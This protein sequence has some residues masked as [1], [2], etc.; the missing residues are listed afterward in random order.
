MK[1]LF[2][3]TETKSRLGI[4]EVKGKCKILLSTEIRDA[5]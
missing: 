4:R 5:V 3:N 2:L 1:R